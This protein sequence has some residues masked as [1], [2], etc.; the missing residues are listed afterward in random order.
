MPG[1]PLTRPVEASAR[2]PVKLV[3]ELPTYGVVMVD[4]SFA[5]QPGI[6]PHP[7]AYVAEV[8][9][10]LPYS[11]LEQSVIRLGV[12]DGLASVRKPGR[13][14]Q[15]LG[16][17]IK[18]SLADPRLEGLRRTT[19]MLRDDLNP[20]TSEVERFEA[21]GFS[22]D[23]YHSLRAFVAKQIG[24]EPRGNQQNPWSMRRPPRTRRLP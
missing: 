23:Q 1:E 20:A 6:A 2:R 7:D 13:F 11:A 3:F 10:L 12:E 16:V 9:E 8:I 5:I 14:C 22:I 17:R 15:I 4:L 19:V 21:I 24:N 18:S